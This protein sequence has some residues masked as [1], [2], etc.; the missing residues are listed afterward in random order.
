MPLLTESFGPAHR[1]LCAG[2]RPRL[3]SIVPKE[4]PT[5]NYMKFEP[6]NIYHVFNQGNNKEQLFFDKKDY[7]RFLSFYKSYIVPFCETIC[8]CLMPN[9]FHFM[10]YT[11]NLCLQ[12][13]RQGGLMLDPVTNG[14]RKTLSG[15]SHQLNTNSGRSGALFRPK[16]KAKCLTDDPA[17][18]GNPFDYR[19]QIQICFDY[20]HQN[21]VE[22]GLVALAVDWEWSSAKTYIQGGEDIISNKG[23]MNRFLK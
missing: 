4:N 12:Q 10:I 1:T 2:R 13:I 3:T 7:A 23:I 9:H 14:F 5:K 6:D 20:I 22:A 11:D 15:Y 17:Q 18:T 21:P 19:S 8:W 16:T